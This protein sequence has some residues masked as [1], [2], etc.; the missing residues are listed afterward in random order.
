[1]NYSAQGSYRVVESIQK[2]LGSFHPNSTNIEKS[3]MGVV[4]YFA[5]SKSHR[6][7]L[8]GSI[9]KSQSFSPKFMIL[10]NLGTILL[11]ETYYPFKNLV[12]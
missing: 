7:C 3:S 1:M 2:S 10:I 9:E 5:C 11:K 6:M 4:L 8:C 12:L